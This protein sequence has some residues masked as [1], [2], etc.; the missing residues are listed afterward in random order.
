VDDKP[1]RPLHHYILFDGARSAIDAVFNE[2]QADV[3]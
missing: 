2:R 3:H 1:I